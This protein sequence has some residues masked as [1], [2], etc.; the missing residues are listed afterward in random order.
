MKND[1]SPYVNDFS[2]FI[3]KS[4]NIETLY[5]LS[6][7]DLFNVWSRT[8]SLPISDTNLINYMIAFIIDIQNIDRTIL[9]K[10]L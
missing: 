1:Y 10:L 9:S 6:A 7:Y 2:D 4:E 8:C 5:S 3:L